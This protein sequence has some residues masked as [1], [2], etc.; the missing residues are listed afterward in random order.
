MDQTDNRSQAACDADALRFDQVNRDADQ[1]LRN[2]PQP[3]LL[4]MLSD[5]SNRLKAVEA[6]NADMRE[7]LDRAQRVKADVEPYDGFTEHVAHVM[8]KHF[9]H[10]KPEPDASELPPKFDPNTGARIQ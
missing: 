2:S 8:Q 6:D 1:A 7:R 9:Y 10:D 4:S 5:V 3:D